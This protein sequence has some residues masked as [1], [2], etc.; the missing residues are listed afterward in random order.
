[1]HRTERLDTYDM[2]QRWYLQPLDVH[3]LFYLKIKSLARGS[4]YGDMGSP[5]LY[6]RQ[7]I[8]ERCAWVEQMLK[9]IQD[10]Q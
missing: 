3:R 2:I 1:L 4:Q 8:D 5:S 6:L 9:I 10:E 7:Q